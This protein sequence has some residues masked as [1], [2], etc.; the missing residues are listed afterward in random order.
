MQFIK[1]L[2]SYSLVTLLAISPAW[3]TPPSVQNHSDI[4][5]AVTQLLQ[6]V[7][8]V[9]PLFEIEIAVNPL[10]PRLRL[11][12][13]SKPITAYAPQGFRAIG[14]TNVGVRCD[15]DQPWNILVP[16]K[17]K[18]YANIIVAA[19]PIARGT[20]L[21]AT[22]LKYA[23]KDIS[24]Q[25]NGYF[26]QLEEVIGQTARLPLLLDTEINNISVTPPLLVKR[27]E[28][29][30]LIATGDGLEI[31]SEGTALQQGALGEMITVSNNSSKRQVEGIV[32]APSTVQVRM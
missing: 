9:N 3:A 10:D 30:T 15:G 1:R 20:L 19:K 28:M 2:K 31:R 8:T 32:T 11:A 12:A 14:N 6:Q 26:T 13:C 23:R 5:A 16:S 25:G 29:V 24:T 17:V 27:G 18:A 4:T 7:T 22:D 21:T